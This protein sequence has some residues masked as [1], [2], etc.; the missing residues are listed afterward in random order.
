MSVMGDRWA[1]HWGN[2]YREPGVKRPG[3][4]S[5]P[6]S[7]SGLSRGSPGL[8]RSFWL[9]DFLDIGLP[10]SPGL[11]QVLSATGHVVRTN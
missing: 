11:F 3:A 10:G 8:S 4:R 7:R 5:L 1:A 9:F 6:G 2:K